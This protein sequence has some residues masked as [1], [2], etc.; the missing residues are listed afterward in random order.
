MIIKKEKFNGVQ[1]IQVC[2]TDLTEFSWSCFCNSI[3]IEVMSECVC[4][5]M[6]VFLCVCVHACVCFHVR[7]MC[8]CV[9]RFRVKIEPIK[10]DKLDPGTTVKGMEY[11]DVP[12]N[13]KKDYKLNFY[14]YREGTFFLK[15][16][17]SL[18]IVEA[19]L[20]IWL[21]KGLLMCAV[22]V[23]TAIK[24]QYCEVRVTAFVFSFWPWWW[25]PSWFSVDVCMCMCVCV[26]VHARMCACACTCVCMFTHT[27]V[28]T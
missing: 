1:N 11:I 19:T 6:C 12:A 25:K 4:V 28:C 15:V 5:F 23:I 18:Q 16:E 22:C 9:R 17:L 2:A 20:S 3:G 7:F 8:V 24:W 21:I 27:Y 26:C 13:S 10:P 14:A